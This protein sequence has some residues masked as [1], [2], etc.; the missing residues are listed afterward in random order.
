MTAG[1]WTV[2]L[3]R[4]IRGHDWYFFFG[5]ENLDRGKI[6]CICLIEEIGTKI[7]Q[8]KEIRLDIKARCQRQRR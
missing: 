7:E 3:L 6:L 2:A 1:E 5:S 8:L 4:V